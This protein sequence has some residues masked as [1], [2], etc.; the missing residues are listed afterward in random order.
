MTDHAMQTPT[1][2]ADICVLLRAHAE[3]RWL[4]KHVLPPLHELEQP[5]AV[6]EI[7]LGAAM[8]YMEV[9]WLD[10]RQRAAETDAAFTALLTS[11]L[12]DCDEEL[13]VMAQ[14]YHAAVRSL[15]GATMRRIANVTG[16][17]SEQPSSQPA[18]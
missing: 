9:L 13:H 7:Q 6:C 15:R 5:D 3:Q 2:P 8:A 1:H 12:D 10:A 11:E 4:S 17:G 18:G 16:I 14:R